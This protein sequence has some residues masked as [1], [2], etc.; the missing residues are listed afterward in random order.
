MNSKCIS[1]KLEDHIDAP[2][3]RAVAL[4]N[5]FGIETIFSCCGFDYK[6]PNVPKSHIHNRP[7]ILFKATRDNLMKACELIHC[8]QFAANRLWW[9]NIMPTNK[10]EPFVKAL[11]GC[12]FQHQPRGQINNWLEKESPHNHE[13]ANA[14][15]AC[16]EDRLLQFS[17]RMKDEV[18]VQ[19]YNA[20]MKKVYPYWQYDPCEP[21]HINKKDYI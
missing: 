7:Q 8:D 11:I 21:W 3:K 14:V 18:V 17:D 9:I 6:N 16:L 1:Y 5:L 19:D 20:V 12:V 15:I 13:G 10:R 2:I 4:M